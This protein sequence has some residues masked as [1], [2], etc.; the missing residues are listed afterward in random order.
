MDGY[1][2]ATVDPQLM[3]QFESLVAEAETFARFRALSKLMGPLNVFARHLERHDVRASWIYPL[4]QA[5]LLDV[6]CWCNAEDVKMVVKKPDT[7]DLLSST[8]RRCWR[9]SDGLYVPQMLL[10]TLLDPT[11]CP[12]GDDIPDDWDTA[13]E[14]V[15]KNFY[16]EKICW[17]PTRN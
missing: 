2:F 14:H 9:G 15:L 12:E 17:M 11:T 6:E 10:A 7:F 13:C 8:L 4:F 1:F 5:L 3:R 16:T